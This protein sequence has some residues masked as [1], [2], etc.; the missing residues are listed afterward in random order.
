MHQPSTF[1]KK[2]S[3]KAFLRS[4]LRFSSVLRDIMSA[5]TDR[6]M[7][8]EGITG[9]LSSKTFSLLFLLRFYHFPMEKSFHPFSF[10]IRSSPLVQRRKVTSQSF[11]D[12]SSHLYM[13]SCPSVR[14]S[15][16]PSVGNPFFLAPKM[17]RFLYE[18][19][20]AVQHRHC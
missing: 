20:W 19:H 6:Q 16:G 10:S 17:S 18:N 15:V 1:Y 5:S 3:L 14:P 11:L 8:V 2:L 9:R 7:L 12:A 4:S 13:R